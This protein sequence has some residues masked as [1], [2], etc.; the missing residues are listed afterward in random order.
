M[1]W[2]CLVHRHSSVDKFS[3]T[4]TRDFYSTFCAFYVIHRKF[5][6]FLR[7]F[8]FSCSFSPQYPKGQLKT[9]SDHFWYFGDICWSFCE[10]YRFNFHWKEN[11]SALDF[12]VFS[13]FYL[14][15]KSWISFLFSS[16]TLPHDSVTFSTVD[17]LPRYLNVSEWACSWLRL[18]IW[19]AIS[20]SLYRNQSPS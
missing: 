9:I 5:N 10:F 7:C 6:W 11:P 8:D 4:S 20:N 16:I 15:E 12:I 17:S 14:N 18:K 3:N 13:F 2:D 1:S 19:S